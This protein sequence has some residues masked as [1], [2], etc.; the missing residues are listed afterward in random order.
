MTAP[1]SDRAQ[2][3]ETFSALIQALHSWKVSNTLT[4]EVADAIDQRVNS[5]ITERLGGGEREAVRCEQVHKSP[6]ECIYF[7][8]WSRVCDALRKIDED[9]ALHG[10]AI[11]K[12]P[13]MIRTLAQTA[14]DAT[15]RAETLDGQYNALFAQH[16]AVQDEN[17][18]LR[19][20][21][22]AMTGEQK[23][24]AYDVKGWGIFRCK[25]EQTLEKELQHAAK[26]T[27]RTD[28]QPIPLYRHPSPAA[29][30]V[31]ACV[32]D[33]HG[34]V[35]TEWM[36]GRF[37]IA[38]CVEAAER[39]AYATKRNVH[40]LAIV[41]PALTPNADGQTARVDEVSDTANGLRHVARGP[42][43]PQGAVAYGRTA[44]DATQLLD[45]IRQHQ[46]TPN[47]DGAK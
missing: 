35:T 18:T 22:D 31:G 30:V 16:K 26:M 9:W 32:V 41:G 1:T 29:R 11:D 24:W 39:N 37:T 28:F 15:A 20:Q 43:S 14:K 4:L 2:Q 10:A 17:A 5:L 38:E 42:N 33:E 19:A 8:A 25:D 3:R 12:A 34:V 45:T 13:E 27:Y 7:T 40:K 36:A 47:A 44:K 21:L 46:S 23:P 6:Y